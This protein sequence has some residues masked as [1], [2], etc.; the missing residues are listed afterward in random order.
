VIDG[1]V[2]VSWP[3]ADGC[4]GA[5]GRP[6]IGV[7]ASEDGAERLREGTPPALPPSTEIPKLPGEGPADCAVLGPEFC[8]ENALK[9]ALPCATVRPGYI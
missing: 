7:R 1:L 9:T 5:S 6:I 3:K 4:F 8:L 2:A